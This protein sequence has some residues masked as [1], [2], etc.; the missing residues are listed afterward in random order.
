MTQGDNSDC[1]SFM[2]ALANLLL[3]RC[4]VH[5]FLQSLIKFLKMFV[6]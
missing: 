1:G 6:V 3:H 5:N 2:E 4:K